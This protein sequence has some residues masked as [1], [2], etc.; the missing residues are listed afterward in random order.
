MLI[1]FVFSRGKKKEY[2]SNT[3]IF[4]CIMEAESEGEA[5]LRAYFISRCFTPVT[6]PHEWVS[7][8]FSKMG[9]EE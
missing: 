2:G 8:H 7:G 6:Y 3:E 4:G 5:G 1:I 9:K